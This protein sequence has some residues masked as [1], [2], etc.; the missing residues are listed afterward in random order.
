MNYEN[1]QTPLAAGTLL[2]NFLIKKV[3]GQGGLAITYQA[4]DLD[5]NRQVVIMEYFP[6]WVV[7][8]HN[9]TVGLSIPDHQLSDY[10]NNLK[11]FQYQAQV[12]AMFDHPNIVKVFGIFEKNNTAYIVM[13]YVEGQTFTE[14]QQFSNKLTEEDLKTKILPIL[15]ALSEIH[16]KELLHLLIHPDSIL[17]RNNGAPVL[18]DFCGVRAKLSL[19]NDAN[20]EYPSMIGRSGFSPIEQYSTKPLHNEATDLYAF[21]MTLY[22]LMT[23][24]YDLPVWTD[25]YCFEFEGRA[26]PLRNIREAA[27]GYDEALYQ[28]VE[29]CIQLKQNKRPQNVEE[30]INMLGIH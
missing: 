15:K 20:T 14:Y 6:A 24:Q 7:R 27:P 21:G 17:I 25:R 13:E 30:L 19:C 8:N 26:D 23:N 2:S 29:A 9:Q 12:L 1:Q 22:S 3:L 4:L 10:K 28:A 11:Q 5:L 16:K 18:I